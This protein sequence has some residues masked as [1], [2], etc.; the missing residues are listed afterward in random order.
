MDDDDD[1]EG[2]SKSGP[3]H[4]RISADRGYSE[5]KSADRGYPME[6]ASA[7]S[8]DRNAPA[9]A[10]SQDNIEALDE[11]EDFTID[12]LKSLLQNFDFLSGTE[13]VRFSFYI[14]L[15]F[16][17]R[18]LIFIIIYLNFYYNT[19]FILISINI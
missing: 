7:Q 15:Y 13:Q 11:G 4:T 19:N 3:S 12:E 8:Y 10:T 2:Y 6:E 14:Y 16:L 9:A 5:D 1:V 18:N 17:R